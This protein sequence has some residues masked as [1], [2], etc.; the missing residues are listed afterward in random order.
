MPTA[1]MVEYEQASPEVR[2]VFDDIMRT[3]G[4][5]FVPNFWKTLA[6]HPPLLE[7]VWRGLDRAMRRGAW[8][9]SPRR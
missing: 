2:A 4:I 7:E 6:A 1:P 9:R 8:T 5:D 3:K